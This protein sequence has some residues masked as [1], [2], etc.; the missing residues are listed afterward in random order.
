[1][2]VGLVSF[3]K[4]S[5]WKLTLSSRTVF[6]SWT[7][8]FGH[9]DFFFFFFFW[10]DLQYFTHYKL[11]RHPKKLVGIR[12]QDYVLVCNFTVMEMYVF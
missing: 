2:T 8:P 9:I 12:I 5:S 6:L 3:S 10:V 7:P 4:C 1:M 11:D